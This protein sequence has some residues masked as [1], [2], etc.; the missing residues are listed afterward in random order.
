MALQKR[1]KIPKQITIRFM[2]MTHSLVI[3]YPQDYEYPHRNCITGYILN[4][5]F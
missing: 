1:P 4:K 3:S 2:E 5:L